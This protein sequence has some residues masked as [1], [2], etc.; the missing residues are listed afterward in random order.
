M[1]SF[2]IKEYEFLNDFK[3]SFK[4]YVN[5][6]YAFTMKFITNPILADYRENERLILVVINK[7]VFQN[8]YSFLKL[9]DSNMQFSAFPCLE[10]A[11]NSMRL[12]KV[13]STNPE[14]MHDY[15]TK[16]DFSLD[17]CENRFLESQKKYD[18]D[19][20]EFSLREFSNGLHMFNTF[21]LKNSAISSQIVDNNLYLGLSCGDRLSDEMQNEVRK[22]LVGAY[23]SLQIHT[24]M[25]FNGG[26]DNELE[27]IEDDMYS[28]FLEYVKKFS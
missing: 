21:E 4:A 18:S 12:Y 10:A 3:D 19:K 6:A 22:N 20:E 26:M 2:T 1:F 7:A 17:E 9:N 15:I 11:V 24:K 23:L 8:L 14:F 16:A 5:K 25:F 13:L 27:D 28:K